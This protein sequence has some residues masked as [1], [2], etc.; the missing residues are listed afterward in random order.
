MLKLSRKQRLRWQRLQLRMKT[1]WE[2]FQVKF[3]RFFQPKQDDSGLVWQQNLQQK[4]QQSF[5]EILPDSN[6]INLDNRSDSE[7]ASLDQEQQ[8]AI[9]GN[10]TQSRRWRKKLKIPASLRGLQLFRLIAVFSFLVVIIGITGFF[11]LFAYYSRELPKPGEVVRRTG[12]STRIFDRNGVLLY[13]LFDDERSIPI[14]I[15]QVPESLK[16]ATIA[17]EDKDFYKHQGFDWLTI[18]RIPY[19]MLV[20]QRVVGG[21]TLTQQLVK[22]ALLSN[23]RSVERKFKE[24]VLSLQIERTF[25]KDEILEMY[26]NEAPYGGNGRG[27]GIASEMYFAKN[28]KDLSLTES[29]ILAGLPQRPSAY[30]P[31]SGRTDEAGQ[32]LW[33][34]RSLGVARRML[35]DG[36]LTQ[37]E[38][39]SVIADFENVVFSRL[40]TNVKAPH[41]VFYVRDVLEEQY[42]EG[43]ATA[44]LSVVTSLDWRIQEE[45]Q[46]IVEEELEKV[47]NVD[48]SNGAVLI[49]DPKNGEILAMI[50]SKNYDDKEIGGEY[51]V[52]VDGL[53]QPGSAIKPLTYLAYLRKGYTPATMIVDA[54]TVFQATD[55]DKPYQPKNYDGTFR[56][57]VSIR[58]SLGSSLNIPAVKALA[59]VGVEEFLKT[60]EE[61]GLKALAPTPENL[62][63]F[64][65]AVTL[66]GAEVHMID[67]VNAYSSF[68]NGGL[69]NE[70]VS[71]LKVTDASNRKLFEYRPVQ[72]LRIMSEGEAFLINNILADNSARALAFGT[73]SLLNMGPGV[74]VK[75]GTTNDQR[76]NWAIGWTNTAIVG[77]WVGN[78]DNSP[79]KR[80]ASGVT[81]A[82]PIWRRSLEA[83]LK[84]QDQK[85][86]A[87]AMPEEVEEVEVNAISGYPAYGDLPT[88]KDYV[89]KGTLP[90]LPDP[91][92]TKLKLC[93]GELKLAND[94][95]VAS[96]DFDE[97]EFIILRENDP[98]S[99]DGR[100]RWQ[101]GIDAWI[102]GK[103]DGRYKIPTEYCGDQNEV[104][105]RLK[106]PE[107]KKTYDSERIEVEVEADSGS[108]IE[109]IEIWVNGSLREEIRSSSHKGSL[110]LPKGQ[111]EI[112]AKAVSKEK[113]EARSGTARIGTGGASWE[114]PAPTPE[115]TPIV[116]PAP[117]PEP[118]PV[119]TPSPTPI[120]T[121]S[122]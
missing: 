41:F 101:E 122:P 1:A 6:K 119:I 21:S 74:S 68:A 43:V 12:Y 53:R 23:E 82:T 111:H 55:A 24:F 36:Y 79:M 13:D 52:V 7:S 113:K 108:G 60:A 77:V 120:I 19:N 70:P 67:L 9:I 17:I 115:P 98:V 50:G 40:A 8:T 26:L 63:R 30:S 34:M 46:K 51:N 2:K 86:Q 96:G 31:Y 112:Y 72:G 95:R 16:K 42:G 59:I 89:I 10:M 49:I 109:K 71:I 45:V 106:S 94:A 99:Q 20:R 107:D 11:V 81:G 117:T 118:T 66:G 84:I 47:K 15:D 69:K 5:H 3:F 56:G 48:I 39:D 105:I 27:V 62:K 58:N 14:K 88:K 28:V 103:D 116:T 92:H 33:K 75:T 80:V 57:P 61:F 38:Y 76:D 85:P 121:P 35:E 18:F 65:L 29:I 91:I 22:N 100:N 87:W 37:E 93:R 32:P 4:N 78:N 64:G 114:K 44:G 104:F 83:V 25:S 97:K 90:S 102:A 110:D 54:E 73:G